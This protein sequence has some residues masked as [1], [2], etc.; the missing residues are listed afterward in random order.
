MSFSREIQIR[1]IK[2]LVELLEL[3]LP[4]HMF[5]YKSTLWKV[6]FSKLGKFRLGFFSLLSHFQ[7]LSSTYG[8][9]SK[10][11][12]TRLKVKLL[13]VISRLAVEI[14]IQFFLIDSKSNT[15]KNDSK[16]LSKIRPRKLQISAKII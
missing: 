2:H 14:H 8:K 11:N 5:L 7:S 3:T 10:I 16:I 6:N 9:Y 15:G 13:T 12:A 1:S 4:N